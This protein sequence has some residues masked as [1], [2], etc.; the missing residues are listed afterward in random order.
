MKLGIAARLTLLLAAGGMLVVALTGYYVYDVSRAL[1]RQSAQNELLTANQV[2][3]RRI[4]T[5]REDISRDLYLLAHLP[6][7]HAVLRGDP[8]AAASTLAEVFRVLLD[9]N[10]SYFQ[11]RLIGAADHGL[12]RVRVD[13]LARGSL[14][15]TGD[16]LQEKGHY[17]YVFD[18]LPLP[19]GTAYLSRI[20]INQEQGAHAGMGKP[21]AILAMPVADAKG[22]ALGVVVINVDLA[23][24]FALLAA[25]LPRAFQLYFANRDGDYL[26]H[27]DSAQTFGFDRGRRNLVQDEFPATRALV[28]GQADHVLVESGAGQHAPTPVVAA[29]QRYLVRVATDES[30]LILGLALPMATVVKEADQLGATMLNIVFGLWLACILFAVFMAR[31]IA[32]PLKAMSAAVESFDDERHIAAL[33]VARSDEIGVLARNF[34][35]M[36]TQIREQLSALEESRRQHAHRAQHDALTGL[37]NSA[38][39]AD[40]VESALAAA[41]RDET[42]LALL[43]IDLDNFKPVNDKLGHAVGD[44]LLKVIATRLRDAVRES[45]TAARI[46]GD[47]FVILLRQVHHAD[48]AR[49]VAEKIRQAIGEPASIGSHR[50]VVSASIGIALYP[51]H[52]AGLIELSR[53]ADMAM[54]RA[55]EGGRD[56]IVLYVP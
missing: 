25:D 21:T 7:T 50:V 8:D 49:A 53:H 24:M 10:P 32:R 39:F 35:H 46:G 42:R 40:R 20:T 54:Y 33:P 12:E 5:A 36:R 3:G 41:R 11:I 22:K 29:F 2:L 6:A 51:E 34:R 18:T 13:R 56:A 44:E 37:P 52:G 38:L 43:F 23:G 14:R 19:P 1:L 27:P 31:F 16:A 55:K 28:A 48:E 4:Q 26:I 17:P 45:D 15:I 30:Q 9:A 47:E